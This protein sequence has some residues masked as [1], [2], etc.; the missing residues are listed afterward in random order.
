MCYSSLK[1]VE[2]ISELAKERWVLKRAKSDQSYKKWNKS[3]IK[4]LIFND[5][6]ILDLPLFNKK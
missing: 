5:D 6:H 4:K 1:S 2:E 3:S